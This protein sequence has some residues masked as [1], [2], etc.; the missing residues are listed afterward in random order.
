MRLLILLLFLSFNLQAQ[1]KDQYK[2][3]DEY[4][5]QLDRHDRFM[6]N[7][8][9]MKGDKIVYQ[10]EVGWHDQEKQQ[11]LTPASQFRIGSITKTYTAT[12]VLKLAEEGKLSL[13]DNLKKY[14]PQV[15]N[16]EKITL[17][18]MLNHSS[19]MANYTNEKNFG[20]YFT[21]P[22]SQ[23]DM[24]SYVEKL[25]SDFEPGSKHEYSN[26]NFLLLGYIIEKVT[27][28]SYAQVLE[29]HILQPLKLKNTV[30]ALGN[31]SLAKEA[32]S[33]IRAEGWEHMPAWNLDV[34]AAAGA[35]R[36][37]TSDL[38][39]FGHGLFQGK[40]LKKSSLKEMTKFEDGYGLGLLSAPFYTR[41]LLSHGG[42]IEGFNSLLAH[43]QD[44]DVTFVLLSNANN[45][46]Q[47]DI[48]IA[49]ASAYYGKEFSIPDMKE[50]IG[51]DLSVKTLKQYEGN[52]STDA[53]PLDIKIFIKNNQLYGQATG[54]GAFPLK[55]ITETKFVFETAMIELEFVKTENGFEE[56]K[57]RQSGAKMLFKRK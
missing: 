36:A 4:F 31:K 56:M 53:M 39:R 7:V 17:R 33:Y 51:I 3:L 46:E 43:D 18:Q 40:V 30:Y 1:K 49:V 26:T 11:K 20:D 37:T 15:K 44:E 29:Q 27:G 14:F 48:I 24:L 52:Y 8:L 21:Q 34:A 57:F 9:I 22:Q 55:A 2:K 38:A 10:N 25:D 41:T 12:L 23:A 19:G 6:G 5:V 28:Q 45:F 50:K 54:Q 32:K 42:K 35:M 16:A 13:S 47:N